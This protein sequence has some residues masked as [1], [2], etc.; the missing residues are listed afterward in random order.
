MLICI[1]VSFLGRYFL[2]RQPAHDID[3]YDMIGRI[4]A[5]YIHFIIDGFISHALL[6]IC[7]HYITAVVGLRVIRK[8][9]SGFRL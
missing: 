4:I 5:V 2:L 9:E 3:A 8:P 1:F 6:T 7:L